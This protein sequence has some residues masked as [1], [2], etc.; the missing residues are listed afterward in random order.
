MRSG[1]DETLCGTGERLIKRRAQR[2]APGVLYREGRNR[3]DKIGE[4]RRESVGSE[5]R[6]TTRKRS[7]AL[8]GE[9][10]DLRE[11]R[12]ATVCP[13]ARLLLEPG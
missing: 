2:R 4:E 13:F 5:Q 6:K 10:P 1:V 9:S 11:G 3:S 12:E 8:R 7:S